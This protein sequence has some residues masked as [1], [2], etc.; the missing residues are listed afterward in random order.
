MYPSCIDTIEKIG[1]I[2]HNFDGTCEDITCVEGTTHDTQD[3]SMVESRICDSY[4]ISEFGVTNCIIDSESIEVKTDQMHKDKTTLIDVMD[5]YKIKNNFN[6]KV[7]I[8][9]RR[10]YGKCLEFLDL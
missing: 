6:Y 8:S 2:V 3:L 4:D 10:R 7:K 5:K 9:D 1:G